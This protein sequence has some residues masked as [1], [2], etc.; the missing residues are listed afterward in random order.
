MDTLPPVKEGHQLTMS[1]SLESQKDG[2]EL[3]QLANEEKLRDELC[4]RW[5]RDDSKGSN[6]PPIPAMKI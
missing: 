5:R 2:Q 1:D 6:S 4:S 3:E